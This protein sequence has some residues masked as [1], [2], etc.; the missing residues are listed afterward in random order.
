MFD[1]QTVE[2]VADVAAEATTE[3][4]EQAATETPEAAE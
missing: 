4:T 2:P 3:S 1:E